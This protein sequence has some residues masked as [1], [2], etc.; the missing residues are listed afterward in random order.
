MF[1]IVGYVIA[2]LLIATVFRSV[3]ALFKNLL[4]D[5]GPAVGSSQ[6]A[7]PPPPPRE[8]ASASGAE[9]P[10]PASSGGELKKCPVCGTYSA[11][12][13]ALT[14]SVKGE[15]LYFC[16]DGCRTRYAA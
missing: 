12:S 15:T 7:E 13:L 3:M 5:D 9:A 2:F 14:K 10:P 4:S 6:R 11:A 8:R 16:S 1:R